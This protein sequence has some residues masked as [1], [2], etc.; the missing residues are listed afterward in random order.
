MGGVKQGGLRQGFLVGSILCLCAAVGAL[1]LLGAR[2]S[3]PG[4]IELVADQIVRCANGQAVLVLRE[5]D[6]ER[7]LPIAVNAHEALAIE[8]RLHGEA[9]RE[10]PGG[11]MIEALGGRVLGLSLDAVA[12]DRA[13]AGHLRVRSAGGVVDLDVRPQEMVALALDAH[14]PIVALPDVLDEAGVSLGDLQAAR[15]LNRAKSVSRDA[16]SVPLLGI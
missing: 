15:E 12:R 14:A 3:S 9:G 8:R 6:G 11:A 5:K 13:F 7:L 16:A 1:R 2:L 4:S 10:A